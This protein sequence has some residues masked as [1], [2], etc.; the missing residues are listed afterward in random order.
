MIKRT[1]M[2]LMLLYLDLCLPQA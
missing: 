1:E 2:E